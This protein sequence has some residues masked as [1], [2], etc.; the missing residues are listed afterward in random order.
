MVKRTDITWYRVPQQKKKSILNDVPL[1][2]NS[3]VTKDEE[4]C[5]NGKTGNKTVKT[6]KQSDLIP[7]SLRFTTTHSNFLMLNK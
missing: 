5:G 1:L 6:L 2:E 4:A 7:F 3:F